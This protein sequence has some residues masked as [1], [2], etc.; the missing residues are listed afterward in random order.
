[1]IYMVPELLDPRCIDGRGVSKY[2][3][4]MKGSVPVS[5]MFKFELMNK[6]QE[7][8]KRAPGSPTTIYS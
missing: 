3:L 4:S 6:P 8:Q 2:V 1:M 7:A 5:V